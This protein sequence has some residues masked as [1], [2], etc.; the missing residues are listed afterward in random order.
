MPSRGYDDNE[1][2]KRAR[3][4]RHRRQPCWLCGKPIDYS[5]PYTDPMA[6]TADHVQP[7][8]LGGKLISELRA[9][10]RSCNSR[11]GARAEHSGS[12]ETTRNWA[13]SDSER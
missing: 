11:R 5:L 9:A 13:A 1:Y 12:V 7:R 2:R 4:L 8:A 3:A 6:F 10:H